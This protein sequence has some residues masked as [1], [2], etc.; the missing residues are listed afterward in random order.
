MAAAEFAEPFA[1][2]AEYEVRERLQSCTLALRLANSDGLNVLV[3]SERDSTDWESRRRETGTY[4]SRC[5]I[6]P[7]VLRPGDYSVTLAVLRENVE[8]FDRQKD[9]IR[10]R[11]L[12]RGSPTHDGRVGVISPVLRWVVTAPAQ[13]GAS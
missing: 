12:P 9:V 5:L 4:R 8:Y 13:V 11:I 2:E 3:S 7:G 6:C 1:I 10:F